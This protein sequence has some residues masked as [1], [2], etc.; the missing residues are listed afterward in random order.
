[1]VSWMISATIRTTLVSSNVSYL[2]QPIGLRLDHIEHL[3]AKGAHQLLDVDWANAA[4]HPRA[5]VFL[6]A[7]D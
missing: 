3:S 1:M 2:A 5:K 6:G 7:D 4:Y